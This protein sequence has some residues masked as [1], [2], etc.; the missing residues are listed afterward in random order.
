MSV[1][2]MKRLTV[3]AHKRDVDA[4]IKRLMRL[5]CVQIER[6]EDGAEHGRLRLE[7]YHGEV[8]AL[9]RMLERAEKALEVLAPYRSDRGS[10]L[11][12]R[13]I[14]VRLDH[15]V[16][17]GGD[18]RAEA[19]ADRVLALDFERSA[20]KTERTK[21][22]DRVAALELWS[23]L[24]MPLDLT[25][26]ERTDIILGTL[27]P[28]IGENEL[29]A[30]LTESDIAATA[31][32]VGGD[33]TVGC[34]L[35]SAHKDD[36][37][38]A[39]NTLSGLGFSRASLPR[40][41][42]T[43]AE[44]KTRTEALAL[45]CDKRRAK[46]EDELRTL[47]EPKNIELLRI[48]CDSLATDITLEGVKDKLGATETCVK[49]CGWVPEDDEKR[50]MR[51]LDRFELVCELEDAK[52]WEEPPVLLK[53]N[54]F[55]RNFEWVL[56]M[57]SYPK[58]GSFDPTLV[59]SIFYF[60]IFGLMFADVGYGFLLTV[61]CFA[62]IR[63]LNPRKGMRDFLA[64]FGYCG[65][66]SMIM[67]VLFGAYFSN[68]PQAIAEGMLGASGATSTM[69]TALLFDPLTDPMS[70]L[71]ISLGVGVVHMV[72]GMAI[73]FITLVRRGRIVDA[74]CDI[75]TWW[76]TFLGIGLTFVASW[77]KY[78]LAAGLV[79]LVLTQGRAEKKPIM[80][81]L[82][83]LLG[84]YG[85]VNYASDLLSY[86]RIL[87]LGLAAGVIGQVV[88][89]MGTMGGATVGGFI[90]MVLVFVVGHIL[91]LA[92]NVLGTFVHTSRLQYIEFFGKFYEDGGKPFEPIT[93]S[94]KYT[95]E[96]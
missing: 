2:R 15:F 87:A 10:R 53:N 51:A 67:G 76:L 57:Y 5:G 84:I 65:V 38:R 17:S 55:A 93:V 86:S 80:K 24:E 85:I 14:G 77:G 81:L 88:N 92:I 50:V 25:S 45:D 33:R 62:G 78:L 49:L 37:A 18:K 9:P 35:I 32:R 52:K 91:N 36:T 8:D 34:F 96:S 74:L 29:S 75:A 94:D 12:R 60:I 61:C 6:T 69:K 47:A 71:L 95:S 56:G 66:S 19:I 46:L 41:S 22:A 40:T 63:I 30:A 89:T 28:Q 13:S 1:S 44:E 59:M 16:S 4:L 48:L 20:L 73:N 11:V 83:G 72:C 68:M 90:M 64:M 3:F 43:A 27:P 26:T 58:Y 79:S 54:F 21:L 42:L 39:L 31:E 82:K 70:F 7:R 23:G